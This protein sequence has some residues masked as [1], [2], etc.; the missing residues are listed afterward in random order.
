MKKQFAIILIVCLLLTGCSKSPA[1]DVSGTPWGKE[2][3]T[4]GSMLG[5]ESRE[6]WTLSR[7]ED[8]LAAEGMYYYVWVQGDEVTFT[9]EFE[10][11]VTSHTAEIHL[12][13]S[14]SPSAEEAQKV[15]AQWDELTRER[16]PEAEE[17]QAVFAGQ[18]FTVS[19]YVATQS[20]GASAAALRDS[21]VI[22]VDVI[23]LDD[24]N[25]ETI[26]TDFLNICHYAK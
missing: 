7:K 19:T 24:E 2:W 3:T 18:E 20:K 12:I 4:I 17:S 11:T 10:E 15:A 9:N 13:L 14:E 6:D 25:P 23:T 8:V 26:L 21:C 1:N 22:R 16:Y 5:V